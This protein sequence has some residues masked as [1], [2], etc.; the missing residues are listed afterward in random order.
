M[1]GRLYFN[2]HHHGKVEIPKAKDKRDENDMKR[3]S[4]NAKV[5]N[6]LVYT[7]SYD[8]LNRVC[9]KKAK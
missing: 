1:V 8:K 7:L 4:L 9:S 2:D 5:M 6:A 3:D